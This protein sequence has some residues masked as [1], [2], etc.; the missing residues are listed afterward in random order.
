MFDCRMPD[1]A[2]FILSIIRFCKKYVSFG[3]LSHLHG[4][5]YIQWSPKGTFKWFS[6]NKGLGNI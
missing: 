4:G 1:G 6:Q 5:G 2:I 3:T